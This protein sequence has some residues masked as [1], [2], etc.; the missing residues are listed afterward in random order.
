[1]AARLLVWI[2]VGS[3][4]GQRRWWPATHRS[5]RSGDPVVAFAENVISWL[6]QLGARSSG[7]D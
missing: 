5:R 4:A 3:F 1:M 7:S 2:E 6:R